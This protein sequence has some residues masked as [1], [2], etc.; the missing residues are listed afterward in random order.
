MRARVWIMVVVLA[1]AAA[2]VG[3]AAQRKAAPAPAR[4]LEE[5]K[6]KPPREASLTPEQ[7]ALLEK[8]QELRKQIMIARLELKLAETKDASEDEIARRAEQVYRLRGEQ[9]AFLAK[10]K[11]LV[12]SLRRHTKVYRWWDRRARG[13]GRGRGPGIGRDQGR[14]MG[15]GMG[16]GRGL[17][18][19]YGYGRGLEPG[20]GRG[21]GFDRGRGAGPGGRRPVR[22]VVPEQRPGVASPQKTAPPAQPAPPPSQAESESE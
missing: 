14:G 12:R 20:L 4:G 9:R 22:E 3:L 11:D 18:L 17:G 5:S 13:A 6:A 2:T 1:G 16:R 7:K 21:H 19:G 15:R 10:N 8:W